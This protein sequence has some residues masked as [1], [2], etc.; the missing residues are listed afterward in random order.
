MF[1]FLKKKGDVPPDVGEEEAYD[2]DNADSKSSTVDD[3]AEEEEEVE[4]KPEKRGKGRPKKEKAPISSSGKDSG[5]S[6]VSNIKVEK[7]ETRI[8]ALD[9]LMK[10]Y[11]ERFSLV[12]QQLG[13]VKATQMGSEKAFAK[14]G[15]DSAKAIDIVKEIKPEELR[16]DYQKLGIKVDTLSEKLEGNKQFTETLMDEIKE[17]RQKAGLFIGTEALLKLNDDVKKDLIE[18]QKLGGRVRINADKVEQI[19]IEV[20]KGFSESQKV[21]GLVSNLDNSYAGVGKKIEK[22]ELDYSTIVREGDFED[23]KKNLGAKFVMLDSYFEDFKR[24]RSGTER[25]TRLIEVTLSISRKNKDDLADIAMTIGDDHIQKAGDYDEKLNSILKIIDELAGQITQIKKKVG[26]APGKTVTVKAG[27]KIIGNEKLK[28][29]NIDVHPK[30]SK[31]LIAVAV[32][33]PKIAK[34]IEGIKK[35]SID[36]KKAHGRGFRN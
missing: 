33:S 24:L 36:E 26:V 11:A 16:V 25:L 4:V 20:R 12:N 28:M 31:P 5:V 10:G 35:E 21:S 13:E 22:L 17:L 27:K 8:D 15:V 19:F 34:K 29:K 3:S 32:K 23:Y 14:L 7:M 9:A 2:E 6:N 18:V 1:N 30:V